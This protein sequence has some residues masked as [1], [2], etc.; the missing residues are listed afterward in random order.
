MNNSLQKNISTGH[1]AMSTNHIA[2]IHVLKSKL[3]LQD[4]DY[5]ALLA[6]LTGHTSSKSLTEGQRSAVRD[7]MQKLAERLGVVQ[8][9]RQRPH[10][11]ARFDQVKAA[12]SPKERKVWALW[13]QLGRDGVV[14]DTSAAALH[15][16][17]ERTVH[18]SALRFA[19][20]VQLD[21]L[22]EALKAWQQ[23]GAAG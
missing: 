12:A 17:V 6:N 13:H 4:G 10:G 18:V 5:R 15:A 11:P 3:Q 9:T 20:D 8:P 2:A 23:R 14:R 7:H 22:I 19:T 21:T 1:S 16:W